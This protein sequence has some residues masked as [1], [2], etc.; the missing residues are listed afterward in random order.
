MAGNFRHDVDFHGLF[1]KL[2]H[3][4]EE[5]RVRA[6]ENIVSKLDHK[7]ICDA[8]LVQE[9]HLFIRLLEWFNFP[10]TVRHHD[11]LSLLHRLSQHTSGAEVL[12]DIG[13]IEF[14]T[15]LRGDVSPALQP[16]I[17]QILENTMRLPDVGASQ[18]VP[19][20]IYQKHDHPEFESTLHSTLSKNT[21]EWT[22]SSAHAP[23][24]CQQE[25][26]CLPDYREP[27]LGYFGEEGLQNPELNPEIARI[28]EGSPSCFRMTTFPWLALTSTDRHVIVSTNSSLQSREPPLLISTCEFLSDVV[29]QDFPAE[30]FLQRPSIIKNLVA[31][32]ATPHQ[33]NQKLRIHATRTLCD[34]TVCLKTRTQYYQ[35]PSLYTPKQDFSATPSPFST[36]TSS[37][38]DP[39]VDGRPSVVGWNDTRPRGDGR[40]GDTSASS[41]RSS[42]T[43]SSVG[44][45]PGQLQE[46][47]D[48]EEMQAL[49]FIQMTLPQ[50]CSMVLEK[51]LPLLQTNSE[52]MVME[53]L[54]LMNQTLEILSYIVTPAVWEDSS[55]ASREVVD[56][57]TESLETVGKLIKF[58]H[59]TNVPFNQTL[60]DSNI[61]NTGDL[62]QHRLAFIGI[63]IFLTKLLKV[64]V[65]LEKCRIIVPESVVSGIGLTVYDEALSHSHPDVQI[66]LLG[67]LQQLN[68]EEYQ[69]YVSTAGVCQ[70]MQKTCKFL[71]QSQD[72]LTWCSKETVSFM[73]SAIPSI[74]YHCHMPFVSAA[75]R[76]CSEIC[77]KTQQRSLQD[78]CHGV[79]LK[80][81]AH[82]VAQIR[83]H[84]YMTILQTLQSSLSVNK[85]VDPGS[86]Q[87][88][89]KAKFLI[90]TDVTYEIILYGLADSDPK[91]CGYA[92]D[93]LVHLL[94]SQLLMTPAM[95]QSCLQALLKGL[96]VLQSYASVGTGLGGTV[97]AMLEPKLAT[98]LEELPLLEKFRGTLR[99]ML[100]SD[101]KLRSESLKRLSWFLSNEENNSKKL[102][103]FSE[104]DVINLANIFI[105]ETPRSVDEDLG[106][107]V[108]Q[109]DGLR[110]VYEIF[111]SLSVDPGVKKSAVDQLAIILQDPTLHTAFRRDGGLE[112][113]MEHIQLGILK[114]GDSTTNNYVSYLPAC[115]TI[116]RHLIHHDYSQRHKFAHDSKIYYTLLRVAL[117]NSKDQ[118]TCYEISHIFMLLL[119]DELAKFDKGGGNHS[120]PFSVPAVLKKRYRLPFRPSFH[121]DSSPHKLPSQPQPDPLL[122]GAPAEMLRMTWNIAWHNG[123]DKMLAFLVQ[124]KANE[125]FNEF[126]PKLKLNPTD[127]IILLASHTKQG[128]QN[129]IYQITNAT[130]HKAVSAAVTRLLS[131]IVALYDTKE[132]DVF[133]TLDWCSA[134]GRF[135]KLTPSSK[136]DEVLLLEILRF[137]SMVLKMTNQT[138]DNI[139]QWLGEVLYHPKGPL[140]GLLHRSSNRAEG[141]DD[142]E[143]SYVNVKRSLDKALLSF[144]A[145]YNSKLPYVLCVRLKFHQL[146]GDL[147]HKLLLRLNV[148][149]APHFYNLA[150]LEGTL[151]CLMH[152]TARPGW[153]QECTETDSSTLCSQVLSCLLEVVSAFHIGRGGTAMSFMGKGVTKAATLC[154]RQLAYEMATLAQDKNWPK[155]WLYSRHG[156]DAMTDPGLNWMLT[157]WTYR[158]PE[159]RTA[160][161]GIAVALTSTV[162]GRILV[163]SNCKHIPGGIWGAAFSI[164]LD[165]SECSMVKEQAALLLV[166]LTS[167][168]MPT[169]TVDTEQNIWQGPVVTDTEYQVSLIGLTALLALLHHSQFYREMLIVLSNYY[170]QPSIYPPVSSDIF[171]S[172]VSGSSSDT[173]LGSN[174]RGNAGLMSGTGHIHGFSTTFSSVS[175][176]SRPQRLEAIGSSDRPSQQH[177][178][179]TSN[180]SNTTTPT[181]KHQGRE[182]PASGHGGEVTEYQCVTTPCLVAGVSQLFRNLVIL[183]PQETLT[184]LKN[185]T[186][187]PILNSVI[188]VTFLE[189]IQNMPVTSQLELFYSD[190]IRMHSS[191]LGLLRTCLVY[192]TSTRMSVLEDKVLLGT[193]VSL[194]TITYEGSSD[195]DEICKDLWCTTLSFMTTLIQLQCI[196]AVQVLTQVLERQWVPFSEKLKDIL[197]DQACENKKLY[198][199]C[200]EFLCVVFSEEGKLQ[201]RKPAD[202][203]RLSLTSLLNAPLKPDCEDKDEGNASAGARLCKALVS[204]Y[205]QW[206]L[207]TTD[208]STPALK[209][210]VIT[211]LRSLLAISSTA[212]STALEMGLVENLIEHVKQTHVKI[213]MASL[214]VGKPTSR[215]KDDPLV[216]ELIMTFDLLRNFMYQSEEVKLACYHSGLHN[217]VHKLWSWCQ[218]EGSLMMSAL[219]LLTT[220]TAHCPQAASSLAF[221]SATG[222]GNVPSGSKPQLGSNS[223]V[224]C[225][226]KL[227]S[228]ENIKDTVLK[229]VFGLL[230][231]LALSAECKNIIWKSNFL[232][233][234]SELNPRKTKK[235]KNKQQNEGLWLEL[236]VNLSFSTEGQQIILKIPDSTDLLLDF[237]DCGQPRHKELSILIIRNL[238]CHTSNKPKLLANEKLIPQL[239]QCMGSEVE[240]VKAVAASALWALVFNNQ[241]AKV[242]LKS[243]NVIPKLQETLNNITNQ[244]ESTMMEKCSADLQ[245]VIATM[246][247]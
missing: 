235:G 207:R 246:S 212:K 110:K 31:L 75:I 79:L 153:S 4:L 141:A 15:Q 3:H 8:D 221:T 108:F 204:T 147:S 87:A 26:S 121:Q 77:S 206:I 48:F 7:L 70:A 107:S 150:S 142:T 155:N 47:T 89:D 172:H 96:P 66:T 197:E 188:D 168:T 236:L 189:A 214:Q 82:P 80:L 78:R 132:T 53:L 211:A 115:V 97:F 59:H 156:S 62:V 179:S 73:E 32:M 164:L 90:N 173:T 190:L 186:I 105:V 130:S 39:V 225:L 63:S 17:D 177:M 135:V 176:L 146:R 93:I 219:A 22:A 144:I 154:L 103:V 29:F 181:N 149:D 28:L 52:E 232:R 234:F 145:T 44:F 218:V 102:P 237:M 18:H 241:K 36:P 61:Q 205:D 27:P 202:F 68:Y 200:L 223:L 159:V 91:V 140:I 45:S 116:L 76:L 84:T 33:E 229:G 183:A 167:Q 192:D 98:E 106:R 191:I 60:D 193:I 178:I 54:Y 227:L 220:Y 165:Q 196:S 174:T 118:R 42:S 182:S 242:L 16:L 109:V 120:T 9:R 210:H 123:M 125:A 169:G 136:A 126:L 14:L 100:S 35:D 69:V 12:Q 129:G 13:G 247:E 222:S 46:E 86:S 111:T 81:L 240:K 56:K 83:Q 64:L 244:R 74:P 163:T 114:D 203:E 50:F 151:Q 88:C 139:L 166:N 184:A 213:N 208:E 175:S 143:D 245:S 231:T 19:E 157:L 85:S 94:R 104:L 201:A 161:L 228:K 57:L 133:N 238:C 158:D 58:H 180:S 49:K 187:L 138:P 30:I 65:P 34:F 239:L 20:C 152:I 23:S 71:M 215:G 217:V 92:S 51:G 198:S 162:P 72:E 137:I 209:I 2:G 55:V 1:K 67:Y 148:T 24:S 194:L 43:V 112:K 185:Q 21:A 134:L 117:L 113:I 160:G 6:L 224:H 230:A 124:S 131:H 216:Q 243:A 25:P 233:E 37:T 226:I 40:D 10:H 170:P 195:T 122:H 11:V 128:L 5:I 99:C 199:K 41:S 119:F 95:W 101:L 171:L 127:K 38:S